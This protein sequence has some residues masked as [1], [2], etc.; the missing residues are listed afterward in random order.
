MFKRV[1]FFAVNLLG[2]AA[3]V[4][5]LGPSAL[6]QAQSNP[7]LPVWEVPVRL[8][9]EGQ[10]SWFPDIAT[11]PSGDVHIVWSS[12]I[13]TG[14]GQA[15]DV[16]MYTKSND[17]LRW[18]TPRDIAALSTK[19]AVTRPSILVDPQGVFHMTYRRYMIYYA[20]APVQDISPQ[21]FSVPYEVSSEE[22]GYFSQV[23]R[24][25]NG[26][27]HLFHTEDV[28]NPNCTGCFQAFHRF[29]DDNGL[30]WSTATNIWPLPIGL[31]KPAVALD[32]LGGLHVMVEVGRGGDLGQVPEPASIAYLN[33]LD[34]GLT[35]SQPF[36]MS[37]QTGNF[38]A[39]NPA[40]AVDANQNL[41]AVWQVAMTENDIVN[42]QISTDRGQTWSEPQQIPG[43]WGAWSVY[44]GKTD[45]YQMI[46]DAQGRVYLALS[47]RR[48]P[49]E[50]T[51]NLLLLFWENGAWTAP[52][53]VLSLTGDVPEWPRMAIGLGNRLHMVWFQREKVNI[54]NSDGGKYQI[55]YA[56]ATLNLPAMEPVAWPTL[57]AQAVNASTPTPDG[58]QATATPQ[59]LLFTNQ[60]EPQT[61]YKE[62]DY[63]MIALFSIL[64]VVL[65]VGGVVAYVR[66]R[67]Q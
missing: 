9:T 44:N 39:R 19:G 4:L 18:T 51:L 62:N 56:Q 29:S 49:T 37:P 36:F 54:F 3:L 48:S 43:V 25:L 24:G 63:L 6:A 23:V 50:Q 57:P 15:Y 60:A 20:H 35:W 59:P 31:A 40:I 55:W 30:T 38:S 16:V 14:P 10:T 47:G 12:G 11:D 41:V 22:N 46:T 66:W 64:P 33:S 42:Y 45:T 26:R 65:L 17:G 2:L 61:F 13:S 53:T 32:A 5:S 1:S 8:S 67:R 52:Q 27:L 58:V 7:N 28:F 21:T 34:G